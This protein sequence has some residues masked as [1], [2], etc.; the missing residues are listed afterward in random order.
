VHQRVGASTK[1][2]IKKANLFG[3]DHPDYQPEEGE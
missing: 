2:H 3:I 1:V